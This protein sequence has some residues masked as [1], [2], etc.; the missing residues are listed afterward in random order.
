MRIVTLG[1]KKLVGMRLRMSLNDDRTYELWHGFMTRR[2]EIRNAAGSELYCLQVFDDSVSF[3]NFT[4]DTVFEKWACIEVVAHDIVPEKMESFILKG[5][6]YAVFI[7]RGDGKDFG[8]FLMN[9]YNSLLPEAGYC[10]D[11][12]EHFQ[13]L[14]EKYKRDDP[15]SEEE[16]WIPIKQ[17]AISK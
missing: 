4:N 12:R 2:K 8:S 9:I 15:A 13:V 7:Y 14:G 17:L 1:E 16:A 5:G 11:R 6:L 3:D 10:L